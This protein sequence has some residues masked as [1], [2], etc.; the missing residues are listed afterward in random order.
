MDHL[1]RGL[2]V[3]GPQPTAHSHRCPPPL[4]SYHPC[5]WRMS[6][7]CPHTDAQREHLHAFLW[8]NS[9]EAWRCPPWGQRCLVWCVG[10]CHPT[11]SMSVVRWPIVALS[12]P[13]PNP[14]PARVPSCAPWDHLH[15]LPALQHGQWAD[16]APWRRQRH[17]GAA[18][19]VGWIQWCYMWWSAA[20]ISHLLPMGG[21]CKS[22]PRFTH[23]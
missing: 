10:E 21:R 8:H 15:G 11:T 20:T 1:P 2:R 13:R 17:T 16:W 19:P 14:R 4:C 9:S 6:W 18:A 3:P 22:V 7:P 12:L 23:V 5:P